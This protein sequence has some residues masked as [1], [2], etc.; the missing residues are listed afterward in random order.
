MLILRHMPDVRDI[1]ANR[2]FRRFFY[3]KWGK[4][5]GIISAFTKNAEYPAYTQRLSIKAAWHGTERYQIDRRVVAVDDDN[6]LI[7][8]DAR[9]YASLLRSERPVHSFSIFFRPGRVEEAHAGLAMTAQGALDAGPEPRA[10]P[11]EF[12]ENLR[13]HD[14]LVT[15]LL[16][17][18]AMHVDSGVDDEAWYAEQLDFLA[19]RILRADRKDRFAT[20]VLE[21]AREVTRRE[22]LR[23]VGWG[24]DYINTYY[25]RPLGIADIARAATLSPFHFIRMFRAVHGIS[26]HACLQRKRA[27]V[28]R[29]LLETTDLP[30]ERIAAEVGFDSR[31]T[32][33]RQL[34]R[35]AGA[36]GRTLRRKARL[37]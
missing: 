18:I 29:R 9:T 4:E 19:E 14:R 12:A 16:R 13:L 1:P 17:Y 23:R 27:A 2:E 26:P 20:D 11:V 21:G 35:H 34:R 32:L 6:Y 22:I 28:A 37:S 25:M 10:R 8:N 3:S 5:D 33:F 15:P 7:V 36:N 31:S 30:Q 24:A